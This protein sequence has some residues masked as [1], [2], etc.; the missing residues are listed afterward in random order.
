ML[1]KG[2]N[3][4]DIPQFQGEGCYDQAF[5]IGFPPDRDAKAIGI[6]LEMT[7]EVLGL[8]AFEMNLHGDD[9]RFDW[10]DSCDGGPGGCGLPPCV[11]TS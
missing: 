7:D 11:E 6:G 10:I 4:I 8:G 9:G 1:G 2:C 5:V 3:G